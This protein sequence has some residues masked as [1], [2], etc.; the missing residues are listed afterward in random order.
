VL[1]ITH[2]GPRAGQVIQWRS[3]LLGLDA[4][5][6]V[7]SSEIGDGLLALVDKHGELSLSFLGSGKRH[8]T[9]VQWR[10]L[11]VPELAVCAAGELPWGRLRRWAG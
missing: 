9:G 3:N 2:G 11:S 5:C 7:D 10:D 4:V 1:A 8:R 6:L